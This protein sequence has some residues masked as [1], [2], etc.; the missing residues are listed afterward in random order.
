MFGGDGGDLSY[1]R[2]AIGRGIGSRQL[3]VVVGLSPATTQPVP[4]PQ[5]TETPAAAAGGTGRP[6]SIRTPA[7]AGGSSSSAGTPAAPSPS[8]Q[9]QPPSAHQHHHRL[10]RS[11]LSAG[12]GGGGISGMV[13]SADL[14]LTDEIGSPVRRHADPDGPGGGVGGSSSDIDGGDGGDGGGDYYRLQSPADEPSGGSAGVSRTGSRRAVGAAALPPLPPP[15]YVDRYDGY[16]HSDAD[17]PLDDEADSPVVKAMGALVS[18]AAAVGRS[19]SQ[20][21]S[22]GG[23]GGRHGAASRSGA[24]TPSAASAGPGRP[25]L[26]GAAAGSPLGRS[27]GAPPGQGADAV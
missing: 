13:L 26:P 27:D 21:F 9:Q 7:A 22:G 4:S 11:P 6:L 12:G 10:Q 14:R 8:S 24:G 2:S 5:L 20:S 19:L 15:R 18:R 3:V 16:R 17:L 1:G 25:D 23:G